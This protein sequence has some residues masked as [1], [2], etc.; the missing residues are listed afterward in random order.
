ME[1]WRK[2][3]QNP[4]YLVSNYGKVKSLFIKLDG[5]GYGETK[6]VYLHRLVA[7]AYVDNPL[8]LPEVCHIDGNKVNNHEDNLE[9]VTHKENI[10]RAWDSGKFQSVHGKDHWNY[11]KKTSDHTKK[12]QSISKIGIL[13][14]RYT[15][16]Y[17]INGVKF[18][19]SSEAASALGSHARTIQRRCHNPSFKNYMFVLDPYRVG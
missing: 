13:H 1:I 7:E 8:N 9:W 17:L 5:T 10:Q 3:P 14:P 16:Y 19:S 4:K 12:L 18:Y 11:G 6:C 15:G 2:Y